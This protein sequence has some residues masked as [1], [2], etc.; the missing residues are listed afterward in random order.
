MY[1][2]YGAGAACT[3]R[4][5]VALTSLCR[6]WKHESIN[7][8]IQSINPWAHDLLSA[9]F[10]SHPLFA[11]AKVQWRAFN[12]LIGLCVCVCPSV[13]LPPR[14]RESA[15]QR[16]NQSI[17][18][19]INQSGSRDR[20]TTRVKLHWARLLCFPPHWIRNTRCSYHTR[21][22]WDGCPRARDQ[23]TLKQQSGVAAGTCS[24]DAYMQIDTNTSLH[25]NSTRAFY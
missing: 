17:I 22:N 24:T 7:Q 21:R 23:P 20:G 11:V 6:S 4:T 16:I 8:S 18:Q 2:M 5:N 3:R 15:L 12:C 1:C 25:N 13:V 10:G 14:N 19:S 9:H